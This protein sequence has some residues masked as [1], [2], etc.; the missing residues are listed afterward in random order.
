[1]FALDLGADDYVTKPFGIAELLARI[2]ATIRRVPGPEADQPVIE[3]ADFRIDIAAHRA[4]A[5]APRVEVRLTPTEWAMA[6][7]LGRN[8][9]RLVTYKQ[10][11]A[12]VWGDNYQPDLNL[13]RV[14][15]AHIRHKLE[16]DP[17]HPRYFV[18]DAGMGYRFQTPPAT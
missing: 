8:P 10:L 15:M 11:V 18:T 14:H 5:G 2:R 16:P 13:L 6:V 12:A 1:V 3:T 7:H 9:D 17:A 4:F